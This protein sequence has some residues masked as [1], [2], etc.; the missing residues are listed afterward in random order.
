V[1]DVQDHSS[2]DAN[3][4]LAAL[5]LPPT[6]EVRLMPGA[7]AT[8]WRV[9]VDRVPLAV[10]LHRPDST[11]VEREL[12]ALRI[13]R[14][15]GVAVPEVVATGTWHGRHVAVTSW[16]A[17]ETVGELLRTTN[18]DE[19]AD[20][21]HRF[22][23]A[24][25]VLHSTELGHADLA[26]LRAI[27]RQLPELGAAAD[28]TLLHL[29]FHPYNVLDDGSRVTGIVD[30]ANAAVGDRR[31]DIARTRGLFALAG[32]FAPEIAA[33][34]EQAAEQLTVLWAEGYSTVLP[35]PDD[36]E[37][38]PFFVAAAA[39]MAADWEPRTRSGEVD[40]TILATIQ[41]WAARWRTDGER[42]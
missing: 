14:T 34:A 3:E 38:A 33:S 17:G 27:G 20:V 40:G 28:P 6:G 36:D 35:M 30:W 8:V 13:A 21:A 42:R 24:Q 37:M 15:A 12:V 25:A 5:G 1:G 26:E 22:G 2:V 23:H 39:S 7:E 29:D 4:V 18:G 16:C 31:F 10:R 19:Q 11:T 9:V 32:V 41:S